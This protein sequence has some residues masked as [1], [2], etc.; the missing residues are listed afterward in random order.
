MIIYNP[1]NFENHTKEELIEI[2]K[3]CCMADQYSRM[4]AA[5]RRLLQIVTEGKE[6]QMKFVF[7]RKER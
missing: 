7:D 6:E 4:D 1:Y 5:L 2:I 3:S